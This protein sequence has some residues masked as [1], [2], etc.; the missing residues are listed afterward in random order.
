MVR[1]DALLTALMDVVEATR[2]Q[3]RV[4]SCESRRG[5]EIIPL[6]V[7]DDESGLIKVHE[8]AVGDGNGTRWAISM[9]STPQS[10]E[11]IVQRL[12]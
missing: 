2:L 6:H 11:T 7:D 5:F 12:R 4:E 9:G 8:R 1:D 10:L 3:F